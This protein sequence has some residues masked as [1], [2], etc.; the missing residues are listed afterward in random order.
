MTRPKSCEVI[1]L[2]TRGSI[3]WWLKWRAISARPCRRVEKIVI[4]PA[5][6]PASREEEESI[7]NNI[8]SHRI[9]K[10]S[11]AAIGGGRRWQRWSGGVG[12]LWAKTIGQD[13][14]AKALREVDRNGGG[15]SGGVTREGAAAHSFA[16]D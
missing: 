16:A 12:T 4:E 6:D 14:D 3:V 11:R 8:V 10:D 15:V 5:V 2:E 7:Q 13:E 1:Q 9:T